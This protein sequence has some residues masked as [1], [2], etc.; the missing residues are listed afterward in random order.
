[1][2]IDLVLSEAATAIET[3][4]DGR[5]RCV[6]TAGGRELPADL[7]ILGLGVRPDVALARHAGCPAGQQRRHRR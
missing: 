7:V 2:G 6:H 5:V 3:L 4:A 1:M